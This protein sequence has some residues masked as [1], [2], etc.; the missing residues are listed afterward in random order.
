MHPLAA[1]V[2]LVPAAFLA[3]VLRTYVRRFAGWNFAALTL[4][5]FLAE[6]LVVLLG[7]NLFRGR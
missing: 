4:A 5:L 7:L 3:V 1:L 6:V 2:F